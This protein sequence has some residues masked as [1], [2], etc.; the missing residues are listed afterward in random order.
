VS[1]A[2]TVSVVQDVHIKL[3]KTA[4]TP[5]I[6]MGV[7]YRI[8]EQHRVQ[9]RLSSNPPKDARAEWGASDFGVYLLCSRKQFQESDTIRYEAEFFRGRR[10]ET[11][12]VECFPVGLKSHKPTV[13]RRR[14]DSD[15]NP[16]LAGVGEIGL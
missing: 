7:G 10:V 12:L 4:N 11:K 15:F 1:S 8:V 2:G 14:Q 5:V 16:W 3:R 6:R 9:G 13:E